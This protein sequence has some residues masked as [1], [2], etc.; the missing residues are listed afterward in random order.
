[1]ENY[2]AK[3]IC[4]R[5]WDG[6]KFVMLDYDQASGKKITMIENY[7]GSVTIQVEAPVNGRSPRK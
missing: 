1:M 2:D 4:F 7:Y 6:E 5:M 3:T